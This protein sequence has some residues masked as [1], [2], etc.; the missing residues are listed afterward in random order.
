MT[1]G[2]GARQRN[3]R[4][5]MSGMWTR[6]TIVFPSPPANP[7]GMRYF[8]TNVSPHHLVEKITYQTYTG[9]TSCKQSYTRAHTLYIVTAPRPPIDWREHKETASPDTGPHATPQ[10]TLLSHM[11]CSPSH[12]LPRRQHDDRITPRASYWPE[13]PAPRPRCPAGLTMKARRAWS[14]RSSTSVSSPRL[15]GRSTAELTPRASAGWLVAGRDSVGRASGADAIPTL[16]L[17]SCCGDWW[18][19]SICLS[20]EKCN[21]FRP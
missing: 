12:A 1:S 14:S 8:S 6:G 17:C 2:N 20:Q 15:R 10:I 4:G 3:N 5:C 7:C 21:A 9:E 18:W 13:S 11:L 16:P 19:M